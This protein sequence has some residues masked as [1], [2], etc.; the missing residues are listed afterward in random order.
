MISLPAAL[1]DRNLFG[2]W[3]AGA[4]WNAW[5]AVLKAA[6]AVPMSDDELELFRS[7]AERDPPRRRVRELWIVGGRRGGKDSIAS[8]IAAWFTAFVSYE[9]LLRPGEVATV[10]CLAVDRLQAQIVLRYVKAYFKQID[11]LRGLVTR[12][13]ADGLDLSTSAELSVLASNFRSV[14]GRTIACAIL[15]EVAFWRD[16]NTANPDIETYS[17]LLP[18]MA[19]LPGA[20]LIGISSPYRRGGLLFQKWKDHYGKADDDVLVIQAPS[21]RPQSD[22]PAARS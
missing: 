9:G 17:A 14:R 6:F 5:R 13:H 11:M 2:A 18:G 16:E 20:M 4:S 8:A 7:V 1:D 22:A 15:D 21:S 12:E 10:V 19:T 3:F